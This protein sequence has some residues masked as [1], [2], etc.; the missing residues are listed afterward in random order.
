MTITLKIGLFIGT[1]ILY[2]LTVRL[3]RSLLPTWPD[4]AGLLGVGL[5][6]LITTLWIEYLLGIPRKRWIITWS[7]V[8]PVGLVLAWFFP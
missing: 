2:V 5:G 4:G 3:M 6:A 1:C 7:T 8:V